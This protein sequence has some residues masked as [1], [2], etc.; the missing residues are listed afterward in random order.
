VASISTN[1]MEI[2]MSDS[3]DNCLYCEVIKNFKTL[4]EAKFYKQALKDHLGLID[5][6]DHQISI[7]S[8]NDTRGFYNKSYYRIHYYL[9]LRHETDATRK[10]PE[11]AN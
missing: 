4:E 11:K 6:L 8:V 10:E 2:A 7:H 5:P 1:Y 9:D 3:E